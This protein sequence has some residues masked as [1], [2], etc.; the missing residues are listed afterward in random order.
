MS[1]T[2]NHLKIYQQ[3]LSRL[4]REVH[5]EAEFKEHTNKII[6]THQEIFSYFSLHE[7]K[8]IPLKDKQ[9]SDLEKRIISREILEKRLAYSFY[10]SPILTSFRKKLIQIKDIIRDQFLELNRTQNQAGIDPIPE[11]SEIW[12]Q[13]NKRRIECNQLIDKPLSS[14]DEGNTDKTAADVFSSNSNVQQQ[15]DKMN[16]DD[17]EAEKSNGGSD[18]LMMDEQQNPTN[19]EILITHGQTEK[20]S[21]FSSHATPIFTFDENIIPLITGFLLPDHPQSNAAISARLIKSDK[22]IDEP[23]QESVVRSKDGGY[24][25]IFE[26]EKWPLCNKINCNRPLSFITQI[27]KADLPF[28]QQQLH[29]HSSHSNNALFQFFYCK[30]CQPQHVDVSPWINASPHDSVPVLHKKS[31]NE[32]EE[33]CIDAEEGIPPDDDAGKNNIVYDGNIVKPLRFI[34]PSMSTSVGGEKF[35]KRALHSVLSQ[36][37]HN[38]STNE[39]D[40]DSDSDSES[41]TNISSSYIV[42]QSHDDSLDENEYADELGGLPIVEK[43]P[44]A[45][46][47]TVANALIKRV[48]KAIASDKSDDHHIKVGGFQQI[49]QLYQP[50]ICSICQRACQVLFQWWLRNRLGTVGIIEQ[51]GVHRTELHF[52]LNCHCFTI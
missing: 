11:A 34:D 10:L 33:I 38:G 51:C 26:N 16:D 3:L 25:Y 35:G 12:E 48:V 23:N 45:A 9:G 8:E 24:P 19:H 31:A 50:A 49:E 32:E 13:A 20:D 1:T 14:Q 43:G 28:I 6:F 44:F 52:V 15:T 21:Q 36:L 46:N 27:R 29:F 40:S 17:K 5:S 22:I 47:P 18:I 42:F 7:S 2:E 37:Q 41:D 4:P 39:N 30:K